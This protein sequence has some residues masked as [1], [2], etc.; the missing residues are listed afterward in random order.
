MGCGHRVVGAGYGPA[1][2]RDADVLLLDRLRL[3]E[4]VI[5]RPVRRRTVGRW[6]NVERVGVLLPGRDAKG[7][8]RHR[9]AIGIDG[10]R[11]DEVGIGVIADLATHGNDRLVAGRGDAPVRG[12]SE[13]WI[14][15]VADVDIVG[16]G[17]IVLLL[18][19]AGS[20]SERRR[21]LAGRSRARRPTDT[22]TDPDR[23]VD[24]GHARDV[25]RQAGLRAEHCVLDGVLQQ[26][27]VA[28][29]ARG[30]EHGVRAAGGGL[31]HAGRVLD[32]MAGS[33]GLRGAA[34]GAFRS[35]R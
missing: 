11:I 10:R 8:E 29:Q 9:I 26:V 1:G 20:G 30:R 32:E 12:V 16:A 34:P 33:E 2:D 7:I 21:C 6:R 15:V 22:A 25:E 24:A 18:P 23:C 5:E 13:G 17:K 19:L 28:E 27:A 4:L 31:H 35:S 3:P 14:G